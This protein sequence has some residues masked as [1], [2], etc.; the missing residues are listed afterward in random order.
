MLF[1]DFLESAQ[2]WFSANLPVAVG[3]GVAVVVLALLALTAAFRRRELDPS[4]LAKATSPATA[5]QAASWE[6][7]G[8]SYADRR[9]AVRREGQL[10]RV[11]L[12]ATAFRSGACDGYVIDRS[13]GGLKIASPAA[14]APGTTMQVRAVGA[15]EGVDFVTV[16]VRSCRKTDEHF[17]IGCEFEKT[18]PWSVLLLFG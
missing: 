1:A 17:E 9:G 10:V 12:A 13:T 3:G 4:K 15:P 6:P 14:V 5:E 16:I 7:T 2:T 18:P 11:V 8:Q